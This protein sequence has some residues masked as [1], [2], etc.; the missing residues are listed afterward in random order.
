MPFLGEVPLDMDLRERSDA[1]RPI[2]ASDPDSPHSR[3]YRDV[4]RQVWAS[5]SGTG[6]VAMRQPPKIVI[7]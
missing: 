7:E 2:V 3:I 1:G 4:A 5:L 6:D